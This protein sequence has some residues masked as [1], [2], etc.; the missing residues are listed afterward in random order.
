ML[1][2]HLGLTAAADAVEKAVNMVW[3]LHSRSRTW[4]FRGHHGLSLLTCYFQ[5]LAH[6][7]YTPDLG[8]STTTEECVKAVISQAQYFQHL[9]TIEG[10][11]V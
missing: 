3:L 1:L 7:P 10:G 4:N 6:G 8:G 11:S 5:V 9:A 2:S